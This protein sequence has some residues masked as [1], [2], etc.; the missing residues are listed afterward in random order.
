M[1]T[2]SIKD[3]NIFKIEDVETKM[4][5][6]GSNQEWYTKKWQRLS[7]CGPSAVANV[8]YYMNRTRNNKAGI[9]ALTKN[10]CLELMNEIWEYVTPSLGGVSSTTMLCKGANKYMKAR[11]LKMHLNTID[12]PKKMTERPDP[13]KVIT[14]ISDALQKD[15]P[16]AFLNLERG[17]IHILDSWHWV[18]IVS[19][20]YDKEINTALV[21]ILDCGE[22]KR[23]DLL[24]WLQTT[25]LGGGFVSFDCEDFV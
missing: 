20:E 4:I 6:Y 5:Y 10:E 3:K 14:F 17:T 25:K 23:I 21:E 2:Y 8:I 24:Q 11:E 15:S 19:L 18:T 1:S 16:V 22:L 7:G 9:A 13:D 12:I